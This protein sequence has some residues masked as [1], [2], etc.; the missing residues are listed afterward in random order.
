MTEFDLDMR[1]ILRLADLIRETGVSLGVTD[2]RRP[3]M[4]GASIA[5]RALFCASWM[6]DVN[7]LVVSFST[8]DYSVLLPDGEDGIRIRP[9][10]INERVYEVRGEKWTLRFLF[11][12]NRQQLDAVFR[13]RGG[14]AMNPTLIG[15]RAAFGTD[16]TI[17]RLCLGLDLM[18]RS[19]DWA[20]HEEGYREAPLVLRARHAPSEEAA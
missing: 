3:E 7:G 5:P 11:E 16:L 4:T 17:A 14:Y 15:D 6:L 9:N 2:V 19:R 13:G 12:E 20:D 18:G 8:I 1:P 10:T